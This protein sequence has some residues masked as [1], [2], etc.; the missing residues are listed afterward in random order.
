[1]PFLEMP[2]TVLMSQNDDYTFYPY[3]TIITSLGLL[4]RTKKASENIYSVDRVLKLN[5]TDFQE[6]AMQKKVRNIYLFKIHSFRQTQLLLWSSRN[7]TPQGAALRDNQN[8]GCVGDYQNPSEI[9][10]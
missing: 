10:I 3:P 6:F 2:P 1:M 7:A 8:N 4:K 5:V 9:L